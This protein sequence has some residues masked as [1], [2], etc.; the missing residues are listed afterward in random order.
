M[1][2]VTVAAS[3]HVHVR[4]SPH[5]VSNAS[6][7]DH[8]GTGGRSTDRVSALC[9]RDAANASA[10]HEDLDVTHGSVARGVRDHAGD[11][12]VD[13]AC[14]GSPSETTRRAAMPGRRRRRVARRGSVAWDL[15]THPVESPGRN[16]GPPHG[17]G[18][19]RTV[20]TATR[21]LI[22]ALSRTRENGVARTLHS[23]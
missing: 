11:P 7:F 5:P 8:P 12:T 15:T 3:L 6:R 23:D 4:D 18:N 21:Q 10:G 14:A 16:M 22:T 19:A 9:V 20:A 2:T 17:T 13:W 1:S